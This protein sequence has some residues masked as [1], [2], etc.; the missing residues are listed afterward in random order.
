MRIIALF[1]LLAAATPAH[2]MRRMEKTA[3]KLSE[4]LF[5]FPA[6]KG[7]NVAV[8]PF[9]SENGQA[10]ELGRAFADAIAERALSEK[11][12]TVLDRQYV[13]RML[14]E[15]RLGMTG[16]GDPSTAAKIGKFSGARYLLVGRIERISKRKI[17]VVTRLL[18]TE[19]A[20]LIGTTSE[21]TTLSTK[22]RALLEKTAAVDAV[23]AS[24]F[25]QKEQ[26]SDAVFLDRPGTDGCQWI[27][28]RVH[29][30]GLGSRD[31]SRAAALSL[32]RR[33]AVGRLLDR[34][35]RSLPDF[36]DGALTGQIE[37]VLRATRSSRIEAEKITDSH[38][39]GGYFHLTLETCLKRSARGGAFSVEMMLNQ[40][41]FSP[42]QDARAIMT[43][44]KN[45]R[46]YLFSVDFD[47]NAILV[48][49]SDGAR[50]NRIQAASP[51]VYPDEK[52]RAAGI[53][54]VAELPK[55]H[56]QSVEMLRVLAVDRQVSSIIKGISR[57]SDIVKAVDESG[58]SWD[59]D[60]RVFTIRSR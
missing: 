18:E 17:R 59:E 5:A 57:Y 47:G 33:K 50:N 56:T 58:A 42:G 11:R 8:M 34:K 23:A 9:E 29:V 6:E 44:S 41:R 2:S 36:T 21:V 48:F 20:T 13:S 12:F 30:H 25:S 31:A 46:L 32:A 22:M 26:K 45:A 43:T 38:T 24:L 10:S 55:G 53:R 60:V 16:L 7:A 4:T 35:P 14:G 3:S 37:A 40:N 27:E 28:S 1:L 19:S 15:I 52:H 39:G 51:L 49:P 54:L